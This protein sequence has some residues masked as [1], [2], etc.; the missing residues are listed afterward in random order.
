MDEG[1]GRREQLVDVCLGGT[2]PGLVGTTD[3][4]KTGFYLGASV[5]YGLPPFDTGCR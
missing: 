3:E 5:F 2:L 4:E 1:G